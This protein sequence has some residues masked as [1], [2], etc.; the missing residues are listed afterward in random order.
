MKEWDLLYEIFHSVE[1][2]KQFIRDNYK[3]VGD[4]VEVEHDLDFELDD[5]LAF[6]DKDFDY[7]IYYMQGKS[8]RIIVVEVNKQKCQ[9]E[10]R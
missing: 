2:L 8:G 5:E 10:K 9:G 1:D 3:I 4:V 7:Y 6:T